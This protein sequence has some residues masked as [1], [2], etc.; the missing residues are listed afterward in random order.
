MKRSP[1][2]DLI[3]VNG[4][5]P[6]PKYLQLTKSILRAID[7]GRIEKG[8]MLPSINE[9]S[10]ELDISRRTAEKG[11]AYLKNIGVLGSVPGKAFFIKRLESRQPMR[12]ILLFNKLSIYKKMIY[13]SFVNSLGDKASIDLYIYNNDFCSF[14]KILMDK[15]E[16]YNYYVI[17]PFFLDGGQD[18]FEIINSIP[19]EKLILLDRQVDGITGSYAAALENFEDDIYNAL[20]SAG[21]R[22]AK[23]NTI[24]VIFPNQSHY[25]RQILTGLSKFCGDFGF[26][27]KVVQNIQEEPIHPGEVFINVMDEDLVKLIEKVKTRQF[28]IGEEVGI[29]SYNETALKRIILNGITTVSTD[30]YQMGAMAA[31]LITTRSKDHMNVP[32]HLTLRDSL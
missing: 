4:H 28:K 9:L 2:F 6:T 18:A 12:I 23:Y 29:I 22:L 17:I 25:S 3:Q 26:R 8:D 14:R 30:F 7:A 11:Y 31:K 27:F 10:F 5:S 1:I 16:D 20:S 32:F 19:K 15:K 24:K 13:E 21:E